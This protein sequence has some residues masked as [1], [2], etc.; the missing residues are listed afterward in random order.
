[1][2]LG[3][4]VSYLSYWWGND[5]SVSDIKQGLTIAVG[6]GQMCSKVVPAPEHF[7]LEVRDTGTKWDTSSL[8]I[9]SPGHYQCFSNATFGGAASSSALPLFL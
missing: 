2:S 8:H 9:A 7:K 5:P 4:L 1:M 6:T 3:V